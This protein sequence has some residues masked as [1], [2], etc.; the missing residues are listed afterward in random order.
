[1]IFFL[2]LYSNTD[3][4]KEM[5]TIQSRYLKNKELPHLFYCF[6]DNEE[7]KEDYIIE[8]DIL[9][10]KG[11]ESYRPGILDKTLKAMNY[12]YNHY[13]NVEYIVRQNISTIISYSK[14]IPCVLKNQ[15]DF[16]G[17]LYY[18]S[19]P[20]PVEESGLTGEKFD[21][22]G[23]YRFVCGICMIFSKKAVEF[24][25]THITHIMKYELVDDIAI[26]YIFSDIPND[27]KYEKMIEDIQIGWN[28]EYDSNVMVYRNKTNN[29]KEDAE[30]MDRIIS[31][32]SSEK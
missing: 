21:L 12:V 18:Y 30:R 31:S 20:N 7:Q 22:Y 19:S 29:R 1:M 2:I 26:S 27:I 10:I 24:V 16:T 4:Y 25:L 28:G 14:L 3:E 23:G 9:Y 13:P 5:Y 11:Y 17:P 8:D 6:S 32:I 15:L